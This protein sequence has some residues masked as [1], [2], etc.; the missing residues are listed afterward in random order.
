MTSVSIYKLKS[1]KFYIVEIR[2]L[3]PDTGVKRTYTKSTGEEKLTRARIREREIVQAFLAKYKK[4]SGKGITLGE[5]IDCYVN[6]VRDG[7]R[8]GHNG[9]FKDTRQFCNGLKDLLGHST[10][11]S[12]VET[13]HINKYLNSIATVSRKAAAR[14]I[15]HTFFERAVINRYIQWNPV[16]AALKFRLKAADEEYILP[17]EFA[18]LLLTLPKESYFQ[19]ASGFLIGLAYETGVRLDEAVS[20]R[21]RDIM[22]TDKVKTLIVANTVEHGTKS[23]KS[24]PIPLSDEAIAFIQLQRSLKM[25]SSDVSIRG[26]QY[27]FPSTATRSGILRKRTV[28][29]FWI[30]HA[31]QVFPDRKIK[32]KSL[33]HTFGQNLLIDGSTETYISQMLGHSSSAVTETHYAKTS[34]LNT[35]TPAMYA[36]LNR[37]LTP[38]GTAAKLA[39][40]E[41]E[42][43]LPIKMLERLGIS[44][45]LSDHV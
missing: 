16:R 6:E 40:S 4:L 33:R 23:G 8:K 29:E 26:S 43:G 27:L 32:F 25:Q 34:L 17:H 18:E 13:R 35:H 2:Y 20:I 14:R 45:S 44:T 36:A 9:H 41:S 22:I 24:R 1:R 30:A 28:S 31:K 11:L 37:S 38:P 21:E 42:Y 10:L 5:Q 39:A 12:N 19:R 15:L 7:V 3:D